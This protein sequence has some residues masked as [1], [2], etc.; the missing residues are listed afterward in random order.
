MI[1]FLELH[2]VLVS[3]GLVTADKIMRLNWLWGRW[4]KDLAHQVHLLR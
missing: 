1:T 2:I 3:G 4:R